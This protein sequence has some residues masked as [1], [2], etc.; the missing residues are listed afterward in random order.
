MNP[1]DPYLKGKCHVIW[2]WNGTL[3]N[4]LDHAVLTV[5]RLLSEENLPITTI[6]NYKK[7]FG[8][9]VVDY[10]RRMGFDTQ[11]AKFKE[12]C[13]RFNDY[14]YAGLKD[15]GLWPGARETLQYVKA[16]GKTQS[17]LSATEHS[18]LQASVKFFAVE[19]LFHHIF[20]IADKLAES[21]VARG[22]DLMKK[23]GVPPAETVLIGDTNHDH[24]VA[25]AL[26][27]DIILVEHGHQCAT[28]HGKKALRIF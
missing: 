23:A 7:E 8:F 21:K 14:F 13:E 12:L 15:C 24:E 10:Y 16:L 2:D 26:G 9:P 25:D 1:L 18:T 17:L 3:L 28:R 4:D 22:H 20:G 27:I 6:E 11:P 19:D 5:N